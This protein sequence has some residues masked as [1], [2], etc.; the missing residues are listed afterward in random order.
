MDRTYD[1]D[2]V[3]R[4]HDSFIE[5]IYKLKEENEKLKIEIE[6]AYERGFVAGCRHISDTNGIGMSEER[7]KEQW[8]DL[9]STG[10]F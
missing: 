3:E 4:V 2:I 1:A 6:K 10:Y 5:D 9:L 7:T 8:A